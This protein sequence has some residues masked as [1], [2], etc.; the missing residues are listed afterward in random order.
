MKKYFN[1]KVFKKGYKCLT[2]NKK[3]T[4][5]SIKGPLKFLY[6]SLVLFIDNIYDN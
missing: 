1:W 3:Q 6:Y 4:I 2:K 5:P